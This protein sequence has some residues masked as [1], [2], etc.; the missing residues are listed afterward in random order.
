MTAAQTAA[1]E[2]VHAVLGFRPRPLR[3]YHSYLAVLVLV[4]VFASVFL[5]PDLG[6]EA[7]AALLVVMV[8]L[9][10]LYTRW[11]RPALFQN[12]QAHDAMLHDDLDRAEALSLAVVRRPAL[13][14]IVAPCL[15][16]LGEIALRRG[17]SERAS[18]LFDAAIVVEQRR[19]FVDHPRTTIHAVSL[20]G[21]AL[22]AEGRLE[23]ASRCLAQVDGARLRA[24][25]TIMAYFLRTRALL[26]SRSGR[27]REAIELIFQ[28]RA[29]FRNCLTGR[30]AALIEAIEAAALDASDAYRESG[31][32]R[33]LVS[34]DADAKKYVLGLLPSASPYLA[35]SEW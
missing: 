8:V 15:V 22:I 26:L 34:V 2:K 4:A 11:W 23:D 33:Q 20:A 21:L 3:S 10:V 18:A 24:T 5:L 35:D 13:D 9:L 12:N 16:R 30:D 31:H 32:A 14:Q 19:W 29:L 1:M 28:Q 7:K 25:G 6:F 27:H 17:Q